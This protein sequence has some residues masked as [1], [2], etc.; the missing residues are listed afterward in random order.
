MTWATKVEQTSKTANITSIISVIR[1]LSAPFTL[2]IFTMLLVVTRLFI[3]KLKFAKLQYL[4]FNNNY[5]DRKARYAAWK[6]IKS[7][8]AELYPCFVS[9]SSCIAPSF[10][11]KRVAWWQI[12]KLNQCHSMT[13]ESM[14]SHRNKFRFSIF[15][16]ELL[17]S[18]SWNPSEV[19]RRESLA[20]RIDNKMILNAHFIRRSKN[21]EMLS[22][23]QLFVLLQIIELLLKTSLANWNNYKQIIA[24]SAYLDLKIRKTNTQLRAY[25]SIDVIYSEGKQ[26]WR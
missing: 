13:A 25:F 18:I 21:F 15:S 12:Q 6:T 2:F 17:S 3:T 8:L 24:L 22:S 16:G 26:P 9:W 7:T 5:S 23:M 11:R 19:S 10:M 4:L 1:L 20:L 14:V